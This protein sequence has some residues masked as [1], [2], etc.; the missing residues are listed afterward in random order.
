MTAASAWYPETLELRVGPVTAVDLALFAAASGDHN[1]LHLDAE[2]ARSA[3]F[4]Q[5]LVHGMLTMACAGRLFTQQLGAGAVRQLQTRFTGTARKGDS[6]HLQARLL[7]VAD[8]VAHYE[9]TGTTGTGAPVVSGSARVQR[10][11]SA[12]A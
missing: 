7:E 6:L 1:P 10:V 11:E 4:D 8:G 9:L 3:G 5:P 12:A 2:V